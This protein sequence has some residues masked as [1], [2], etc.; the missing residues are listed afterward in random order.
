MPGR[1]R[2]EILI[3]G[4]GQLIGGDTDLGHIIPALAI[5]NS[6]TIWN[7]IKKVEPS[8]QGD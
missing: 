8:P 7:A 3:I 5:R 4:R 1:A 6:E 2:K